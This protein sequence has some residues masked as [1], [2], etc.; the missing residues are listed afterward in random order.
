MTSSSAADRPFEEVRVQKLSHVV[1]ERLRAQIVQGERK[2]GDKLPSETEL[3]QQFK[4][5]RPTV[6]EALR[7]LEVES[8]I[9]MGRGM[10]SGA[11]VLAPSTERAAAYAAMVLTSAGTTLGELHAT[12]LIL[13]PTLVM[14]LTRSRSKQL[15][16]ALQQELDA[17]DEALTAGEFEQAVRRFNAFHALLIEASGNRALRLIIGIVK[18]LSERS[19]DV[20]AETAGGG[21]V[22]LR[23]NLQKTHA[24]YQQLLNL[25][26]SGNDQEAQAFWRKYMERAQQYLERTGLGARKIPHLP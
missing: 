3:L 5:S 7:I 12:R 23:R 14:Q 26:K 2:P 10:R 8:F 20:L 24:A 22:A 19:I 21:D 6:R 9:S 11:T 25:M 13:E 15:L 4:V 1:A 18:S 16:D 17:G